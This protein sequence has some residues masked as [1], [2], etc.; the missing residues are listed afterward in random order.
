MEKKK[1]IL[2]MTLAVFIAGVTFFNIYLNRNISQTTSA[3]Q[4]AISKETLQEEN[5]A[6]KKQ[7][8]EVLPSAQEQQR[9]NYLETV[10]TFL[11]VSYHQEKE[12][13][14]ERKKKAK[15][16]MSPEL[17]EQF[18]PS[19]QF[20]LGGTYRSKPQDIQLYLQQ[21]D[22]DLEEVQVIA[23]FQNHLQISEEKVEETTNIIA[24]ISLRKEENRWIVTSIEPLKNEIVPE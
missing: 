2:F 5:Q 24:K 13:F 10:N 7:L 1:W 14:T 3:K 23:E 17:Y 21:Y 22:S 4:E 9:R 19:A 11:D 15:R 18:Y 6:L 8:K 16:I 20:E 12:G